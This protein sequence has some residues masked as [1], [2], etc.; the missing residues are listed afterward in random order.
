[1]CPKSASAWPV[2]VP[3]NGAGDRE[4]LVKK[5][6]RE[7]TLFS[8]DNALMEWPSVAKRLCSAQPTK[9][10]A[11]SLGN[12]LQ[13][14]EIGAPSSSMPW[15]SK[16]PKRPRAYAMHVT[17]E[18]DGDGVR[19]TPMSATSSNKLPF[20]TRFVQFA[21]CKG[22]TPLQLPSP[23]SFPSVVDMETLARAIVAT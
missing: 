15:R 5:R 6:A 22:L 17:E 8:D 16:I 11:E 18:R 7:P 10:L 23:D 13:S 9:L 12:S 4:T 21:T 19:A 1:M 2:A 20:F 3:E 14:A